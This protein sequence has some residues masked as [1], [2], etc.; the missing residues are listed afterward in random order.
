MI[1]KANIVKLAN[2]LPFDFGFQLLAN[3]LINLNPGIKL[4]FF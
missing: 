2:I 1:E 4:F 3:S